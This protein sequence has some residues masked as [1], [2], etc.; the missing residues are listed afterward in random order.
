VEGHELIPSASIGIASFPWGEAGPD[1]ILRLAD[2]AM[3]RAKHA[4]G[5]RIFAHHPDAAVEIR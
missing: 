4:G 5:D 1:A 3:Y 2:A